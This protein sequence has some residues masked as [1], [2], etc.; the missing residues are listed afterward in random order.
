MPDPT[1]KLLKISQAAKAAGVS[2]QTVE[3]YILLG[4]LNPITSA[5][6]RRRGFRRG[7]GQTHQAHSRTQRERLHPARHRHDLA[8][9]PLRQARSAVERFTLADQ[10][11]DDLTA[12]VVKKL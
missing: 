1:S 3:Y 12:I 4:L 5:G 11:A 8:E 6:S 2:V 10:Q 9:E 7:A